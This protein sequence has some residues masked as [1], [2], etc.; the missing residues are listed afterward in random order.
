MKRL[1]LL[2]VLVVGCDDGEKKSLPSDD[3]SGYCTAVSQMDELCDGWR[4]KSSDY[5]EGC[6]AA[7]Y[8]LTDEHYRGVAQ[9]IW[10]LIPDPD[11]CLE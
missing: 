5:R 2:A 7:A 6:Y 4:D 11:E 3:P 8:V 1:A 10:D 9:A